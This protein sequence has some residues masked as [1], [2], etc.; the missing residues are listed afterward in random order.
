M[1]VA[2]L[3][4]NQWDRLYDFI[5]SDLEFNPGDYILVDISGYKEI[6]K[7]LAVKEVADS[8]VKNLNQQEDLV[9]FIRKANLKDL[10]QLEVNEKS[11]EADLDICKKLAQKNQLPMKL[12]DVHSSFDNKKITFA[13]IA[14][15]RIDFRGL[16][17]DLTRHFQSN[18]RLQQLGVRDEAKINGDIG[19]CGIT[20]C[21]KT[22]LRVLGN[23]NA[24][25]AELQQVSH[26][27]AERLSGICGRLKC[28]LRYENDLYKEASDKFPAVGTL[29]KTPRGRGEVV[30]W[31]ILK[32]S[33]MVKLEKEEGSVVEV[34]L[35]KVNK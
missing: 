3:Q 19:S 12:I 21:C 27:G 28:C 17:K 13:F 7:V 9:T 23:V 14:D 2:E 11:K 24:E 34:P 33:V 1:K 25:Q 6:G 5:M 18:I 35:E 29:V 10:E 4:L 26:R 15:G 22:H 32:Q 8:E 31:H 16:V 30:E 20:E